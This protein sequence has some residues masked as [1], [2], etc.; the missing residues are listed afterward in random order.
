MDLAFT[1]KTCI[2]KTNKKNSDRGDRGF[3]CRLNRLFRVKIVVPFPL[4]I[5]QIIGDLFALGS[6]HRIVLKS[7]LCQ[8][9]FPK[10]KFLDIKLT[11][12]SSL[13]LNAILSPFYWRIFKENQ[14]LL[15]F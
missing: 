14:T 7:L 10:M 13:L 11:K 8:S 5:G 6:A 1:L 15:W 9:A 4:S 12:D 2:L 3:I